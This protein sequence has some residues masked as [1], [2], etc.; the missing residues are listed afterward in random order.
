MNL[1]AKLALKQGGGGSMSQ[2][3]HIL[4]VLLVALLLLFIKVYL[5][6]WSYNEVVPR[7]T[8][9]RPIT[10]TEALFLVILMQSLFH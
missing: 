9:M 7:L 1:L 8:Q 2:S 10:M 5:V 3:G 4:T 6:Y